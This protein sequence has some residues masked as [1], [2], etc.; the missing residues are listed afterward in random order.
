MPASF[1][2][3]H[4]RHPQ[5]QKV[6]CLTPIPPMLSS[7]A[8]DAQHSPELVVHGLLGANDARPHLGEPISVDAGGGAAIRDHGVTVRL[9][10][11]GLI[12]GRPW[13]CTIKGARNIRSSSMLYGAYNMPVRA[14]PWAKGLVVQEIAMWIDGR[15][16]PGCNEVGHMTVEVRQIYHMDILD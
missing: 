1:L 8:R 14:G 9:G 4:P 5:E 3:W 16:G 7:D 2:D 13:M 12:T 11:R 15:V 10:S 6:V